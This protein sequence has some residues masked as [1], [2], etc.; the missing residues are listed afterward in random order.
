MQIIEKDN[1][2]F[3]QYRRSIN[4]S[5]TV[6]NRG[7]DNEKEYI[8]FVV[9]I[10]LSIIQYLQQYKN[11]NIQDIVFYDDVNKSDVKLISFLSSDVELTKTKKIRNLDKKANSY[12]VNIPK[13]YINSDVKEAVFTVD[14]NKRDV[15]N[16]H[17]EVS[18]MFV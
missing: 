4:K 12:R 17:F 10:P 7:K 1:N 14:L 8:N 6:K 18:V 16:S 5:I 9:N 2:I 3:L 11:S 15:F 13:S